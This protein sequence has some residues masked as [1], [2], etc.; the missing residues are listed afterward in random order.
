MR[1]LALC[2]LFRFFPIEHKS[3]FL[4]LLNLFAVKI[5]VLNKPQKMSKK[6]FT[7]TKP[8]FV[9]AVLQ[10]RELRSPRDCVGQVKS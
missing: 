3:I 10:S 2:C 9:N 7:A 6:F 1:S 5:S 4:S 8:T